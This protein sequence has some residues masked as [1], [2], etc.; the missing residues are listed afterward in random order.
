MNMVKATNN[1]VNI[2]EIHGDLTKNLFDLKERR[3]DLG[4]AG[5]TNIAEEKKDPDTA[6][7]LNKEAGPEIT[8]KQN[9]STNDFGHKRRKPAL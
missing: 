7:D 1:K 4:P 6:G 8:N 3:A 2:H 5:Y 9:E